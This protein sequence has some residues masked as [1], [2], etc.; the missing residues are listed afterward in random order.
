MI[1][2]TP[3]SERTLS[4]FKTPFEQQL[5]PSNRWVKMAGLIPWDDMAQ[6]FFNHM[7]EG[8]G[9]ASVD[10]RVILGALLV[11]HIEGISDED[12]VQYIQENIY[13]QYFVGLPSFQTGPVFAPSLFV[14][15][16]KRLGKEGAGQ[17]NDIVLRQ[18]KRTKA[19][20]HRKKPSKGGG[21]GPGPAGTG[22]QEG[23]KP[24][25]P[26]DG[27]PNK[28]TLKVDATVAPQ[29]VGYPTDTRLLAEARRYS[30]E[31]IDKLHKSG[32]WKKKPRTYRRKAHKEYL[33]FSKNRAPQKKTVRQARGKQLRYLR[34]NLKTIHMMLDRLGAKGLAPR[35]QHRDWQRLWTIQELY[36]QQDIMH[37]D[38][39]RRIDD[40]IVN[41]AQP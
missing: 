3:A 29:H 36:R 16:R 9:R 7:S 10:L 41:I 30:E 35:W 34:R 28:G 13:A 17:L 6:V 4:L 40:R 1:T 14:E 38:G 5:D 39:R 33:A 37:R 32:L 19:I 27:T 31:L 24:A 18:A 11:K 23:G 15:V 20:K 25:V 12:T 22:A 21:K 26:E 8:H 2:Y